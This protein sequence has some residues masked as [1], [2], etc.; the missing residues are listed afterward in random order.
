MNDYIVHI[1]GVPYPVK[2]VRGLLEAIPTQRQM[3]DEQMQRL[4][5]AEENQKLPRGE[6]LL[7]TELFL[8]SE[9]ANDAEKALDCLKGLD[10]VLSRL[11]HKRPN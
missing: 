11:F 3:L 2:D 8:L 7:S 1:N 6:V 5:N 10:E 9:I 4:Q